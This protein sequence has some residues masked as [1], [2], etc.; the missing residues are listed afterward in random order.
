MTNQE[1]SQ[2]AIE[3]AIDNKLF[4]N[5]NKITNFNLDA[6]RYIWI[7]W[8]NKDNGEERDKMDILRLI[9]SHEFAKAFWKYN[10]IKNPNDK[11]G[12]MIKS[13]KYHLQQMVIEEEPIK[14]LEQFI[15]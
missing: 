7:F 10:L 4:F 3:K 1:I 6:K 11:D 13:W 8:Y 15:K 14:Y 12:K 2:K 5:S 9:F